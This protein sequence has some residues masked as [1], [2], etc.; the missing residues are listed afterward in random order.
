MCR[1]RDVRLN[2]KSNRVVEFVVEKGVL[3]RLIVMLVKEID[4]WWE[5]I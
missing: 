4:F 2:D 3:G 1:E 5:R